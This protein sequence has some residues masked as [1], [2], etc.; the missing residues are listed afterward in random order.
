MVDA[1]PGVAS[2]GP[3]QENVP[4]VAASVEHTAVL[5]VSFFT[6]TGCPDV[7]P[8][9]VTVT[10][11]LAAPTGGSIRTV[12]FGAAEEVVDIDATA[13]SG[14]TSNKAISIFRPFPRIVRP[15]V[16]PPECMIPA[17]TKTNSQVHS[18]ATR[19]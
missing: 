15:F 14:M 6:V 9:P 12:G 2:A 8:L 1:V 16:L 10:D 17:A 5:V 13:S 4:S 19:M 11:P 18:T 3:E 7:K